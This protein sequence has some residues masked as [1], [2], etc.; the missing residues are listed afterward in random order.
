MKRLIAI[1][2]LVLGSHAEIISW[3]P[4]PSPDATGYKVY[5]AS[6]QNG[7]WT[8]LGATSGLSLTN[9]TPGTFYYYVTATN[10]C[11]ESDPSAIAHRPGQPNNPKVK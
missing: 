6:S 7:P 2:T 11:C 10:L 4:S 5:W 9:T 3:E 8:V 1:L